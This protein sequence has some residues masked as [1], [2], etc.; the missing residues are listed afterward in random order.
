MA[1]GVCFI[2]SGASRG[3]CGVRASE[4]AIASARA[5]GFF[6]SA[7]MC[8]VTAEGVS[9]GSFAM[10]LEAV[11]EKVRVDDVRWWWC[12]C[13]RALLRRVCVLNCRD[14]APTLTADDDD[15]VDE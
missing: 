6:F 2:A 3:W 14:D 10:R 12:C 8:V 13:R 15:G 1:S 4:G 9:V 11:R 5:S 7:E